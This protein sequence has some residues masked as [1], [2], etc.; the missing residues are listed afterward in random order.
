MYDNV[1]VNAMYDETTLTYLSVEEPGL[2][3]GLD[4]ETLLSTAVFVVHGRS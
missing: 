1:N 4:D 2:R 3:S